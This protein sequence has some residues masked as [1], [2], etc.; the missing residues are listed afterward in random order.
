[1]RTTRQSHKFVLRWG[2]RRCVLPGKLRTC[3]PHAGET[4]NVDQG[5]ASIAEE[6]VLP[7]QTPA[8]CPP[9]ASSTAQ[10]AAQP[11][12]TCCRRS[13]PPAEDALVKRVSYQSRVVLD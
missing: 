7:V 2:L 13:L 9:Q 1:M 6:L 4:Y 10:A 5:Q 3:R 12:A 8:S 11:R